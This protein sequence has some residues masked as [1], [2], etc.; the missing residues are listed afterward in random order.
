MELQLV[1][2]EDM[3]SALRQQSR[4][5]ANNFSSVKPEMYAEVHLRMHR[6]KVGLYSLNG[7]HRPRFVVQKSRFSTVL[8]LIK[9]NNQKLEVGRTYF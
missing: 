4:L 1:F 6:C 5:L 8:D 7:F 3:E 9:L 2:A